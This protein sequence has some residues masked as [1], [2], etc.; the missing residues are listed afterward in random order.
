VSCE[1]EHKKQIL[2]RV[3]EVA[4]F[5]DEHANELEEADKF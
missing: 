5:M 4:A 2:R 3:E 1:E